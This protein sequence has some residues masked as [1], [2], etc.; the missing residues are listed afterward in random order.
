M[1]DEVQPYNEGVKKE[2][3]INETI[4]SGL[5]DFN[6]VFKKNKKIIK[7]PNNPVSKKICMK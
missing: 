5:F 2:I 6:K 3:I 1:N 7:K 4:R